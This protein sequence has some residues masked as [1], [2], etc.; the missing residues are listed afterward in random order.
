MPPVDDTLDPAV[1]E[2]LGA[3]GLQDRYGA[4]FRREEVDMEALLLMDEKDF[5]DLGLS[6]G[7]RVKLR[8]EL[9][10]HLRKNSVSSYT[11]Y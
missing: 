6:K 5:A 2:V 10:E 3:C 11:H 7:A 9:R 4:C 1:V 8:H